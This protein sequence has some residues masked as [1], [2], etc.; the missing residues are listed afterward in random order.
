ML[1]K[2]PPP[3]TKLKPFGCLCFPWLRP[4]ASSKLHPRST[5]CIFLG[6]SSSKSAYKCYDPTSHRLYHSRHVEFI[7]DIFPFTTQGTP[8][9]PLPT[10]EIFIPTVTKKSKTPTIPTQTHAHVNHPM[11]PTSTHNNTTSTTTEP[12]E[13]SILNPSSSSDT[14]PI[15]LPQSDTTHTSPQPDTTPSPIQSQTATP[16][17]NISPQPPTFQPPP[18]TR[19]QRDRKPNPKYYN[20]NTTLHTLPLLNT[21]PLSLGVD[22][23]DGIFSAIIPRNTPIPVANERIYF[24][25]IDNQTS[26]HFNAYHGE[27]SIA[28]ENKWLGE[29]EVVVLPAPKGKSKVKVVFSVD[30]NGTLNCWVKEFI[31]GLKKKIIIN[32]N[33]DK[34]SD[35]VIQMMVNDAEKHKLEDQEFIKIMCARNVLEEYIYNVNKEMMTIGITAKTRLHA[36][37]IKKME[38]AIVH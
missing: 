31:T 24:T 26:I 7:D 22:A 15:I 18:P 10:P 36:E 3:Y 27:R 9:N 19:P 4:Y 12:L 32:H 13:P 34:P 14:S 16:V 20:S 23:H 2:L 29:F 6:Y 25:T 35:E 5:K 1:Y 8:M 37:E 11:Q 17:T 21:V 33:T 28:K 30:D 38:I